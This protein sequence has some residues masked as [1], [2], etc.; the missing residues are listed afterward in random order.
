MVADEYAKALFELTD[1]GNAEQIDNELKLLCDAFKENEDAIKVLEAPNIALAKKKKFVET[2]SKDFNELTKR[3]LQVVTDNQRFDAIY[4]IAA[5]FHDKVSNKKKIVEVEVRS[6]VALTESQ[7]NSLAKALSPK[8][9]NNEIKIIN[10]VD[11]KLIGGLKAVAEGKCID[12]SIRGKLS[13]I[14]ETL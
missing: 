8:F 4:D 14:K 11:K 1:S 7:I 3:F 12:L 9:D 10:I 13:A 2:L 5:S 6:K